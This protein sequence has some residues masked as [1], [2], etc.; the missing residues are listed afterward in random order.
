MKK[1]SDYIYSKRFALDKK[2]WDERFKTVPEFMNIKLRTQKLIDSSSNR[3]SFVV[4]QIL[5]KKINKVCSTYDISPFIFFVSA[6][7]IYLSK[8]SMKKD[9]VIGTSVL[10]RSDKRQRKTIGMFISAVPMRIKINNK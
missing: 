6:I 1:D 2:F 7:S 8:V 3:K 9:I 10:N 4:P 5:S